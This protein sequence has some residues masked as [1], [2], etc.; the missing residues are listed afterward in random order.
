[1]A[2]ARQAWES[3]DFDEAISRVNEGIEEISEIYREQGRE[4]ASESSGE[5]AYLRKWKEE[6]DQTRP[7]T[8]AQRI[9]RE[10]TEAISEENFERAATLRDRL[11][12]IRSGHT[13]Q[14]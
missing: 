9:E 1:M 3:K 2:R 11:Q 13:L 6:I 10:L 4:D 7:L 14:E 8:L 12:A 5:I